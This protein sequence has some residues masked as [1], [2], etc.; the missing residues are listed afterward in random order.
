MARDL[1]L[2]IGAFF[3]TP[4]GTLIVD[5][6]DMAP[7]EGTASRVDA[8]ARSCL[9][10][11]AARSEGLF[12]SAEPD[13]Q[14]D[15]RSATAS[16]DSSLACVVAPVWSNGWLGLLGVV[17]VWLPEL[18]W[19]QREGLRALAANL[20]ETVTSQSA[21]ALVDLLTRS[22]EAPAEPGP[23]GEPDAK[24]A[25]NL[26]KNRMTR[27][28]VEEPDQHTEPFLGEVLDNLPHGLLVTRADGTIVLVNQTFSALTG[29]D[30]DSLLGE[31]IEAVVETPVA[32]TSGETA[33]TGRIAQL[34]HLLGHAGSRA[35]VT[36]RGTGSGATFRV[37]GQ[38]IESRFAGACFVTLLR[39]PDSAGEP[40]EATV[41]RSLDHIEDGIVCA[42]AKG[43]VV[44]ANRAACVLQGLR[45]DQLTTGSPYPASTELRSLDGTP[46]GEEG[47]PL[48][49]AAR[50]GIPVSED[51]V[52]RE[53][54]LV[55]HVAVSARPLRVD[56]EDCAIAV[57]RDVTAER[58]RQEQLTHYALH[59]PLTGLANRYLLDD[60]LGRMLDAIERRASSVLLI[61]LDLDG[62]KVIND[63][64]GHE[65]GDAVLRAVAR[66]LER[67]V[68]GED[69][70]ARVGGDEFVV[71]HLSASGIPDDDTVVARV[72]KTLSAPYRVSDLILDVR[73]SVGWASTSAGERTPES[74]ISR[75]D[76]AM[77]ERK[78]VTRG[79]S[80][81]V[82]A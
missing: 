26:T 59:D 18:D 23:K 28:G 9:S 40:T 14:F 33:E 10:H 55:R 27:H 32:D 69:V 1:C 3:V 34:E 75:A 11:P 72:R 76:R 16:A 30:M 7:F 25:E 71:A 57:L 73:A 61:Y 74:L 70:V 37:D 5:S 43:T 22:T 15:E 41:Q 46:I 24:A 56:G 20:A 80:G 79:P 81:S 21:G 50:E 36:V 65:V 44:F 42:D 13:E 51:L 48:R 38:R 47:H 82:P 62:F 17:D 39:T 45:S 4:A 58:E 67:A 49:R 54:D 53:G 8:L 29:L 78:P 60:A 2:G 19:E 63:H 12:W 66:R 52:L 77:Y 6:S 31:D 35:T 64:Y 68:R